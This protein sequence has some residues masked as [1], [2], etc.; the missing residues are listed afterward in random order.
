MLQEETTD[1]AFEKR[2]RKPENAEKRVR[3]SEIDRLRLD[4]D[5]LKS[6]VEQLQVVEAEQLTS[7][8][9]GAS[10]E[11]K[12]WNASQLEEG[13]Q[14]LIRDAQRALDRHEALLALPPPVLAGQAEKRQR[15]RDDPS[16]GGGATAAK[17]ARIRV[18]LASSGS[19]GSQE[20]A[21][22]AARTEKVRRALSMS[23]SA[24]SAA[25]RVRHSSS[26]AAAAARSASASAAAARERDRIHMDGRAQLGQLVNNQG[27]VEKVFAEEGQPNIHARTSGGR[28]APKPKD[29]NAP[30]SSRRS[31]ANREPTVPQR[32]TKPRRKNTANVAPSAAPGG[33]ITVSSTP[34]TPSV[35]A[36][37]SVNAVSQQ[38]TTTAPATS[39]TGATDTVPLPEKKRRGRPPGTKTGQGRG[40]GRT[41]TGRPP[42]RPR[43]DRTV[44]APGAPST[45]TFSLSAAAGPSTPGPGRPRRIS[46]SATSAQLGDQSEDGG[47]RSIQSAGNASGEWEYETH[48]SPGGSTV[49]RERFNII[50]RTSGGRFA[51]KRELKV[52]GPSRRER[53]RVARDSR[54]GAKSSGGSSGSGGLLDS[55][56]VIA[57]ALSGG[58]AIGDHFDGGRETKLGPSLAEMAANGGNVPGSRRVRI[59]T[60]PPP[61][62]RIAD[63]ISTVTATVGGPS[64]KGPRQMKTPGLVP[65]YKPAEL[66]EEEAMRM[67]EAALA[68]EDDEE[69]ESTVKQE[70]NPLGTDPIPTATAAQVHTPEQ[71]QPQQVPQEQRQPEPQPSTQEE[72]H[73]LSSDSSQQ[74]Q[75]EASQS[76]AAS[77][78]PTSSIETPAPFDSAGPVLA[79]QPPVSAAATAATE[80]TET[81]EPEIQVGDTTTIIILDSTKDASAVVATSAEKQT[82]AETASMPPPPLPASASP[83]PAPAVTSSTG[84]R[85]RGSIGGGRRE[86]SRIRASAAFGERLPDELTRITD[87]AACFEPLMALEWGVGPYA[88]ALVAGDGMGRGISAGVGVG[89][90]PSVELEAIKAREREEEEAQ[91]EKE[92]AEQTSPVK[93]KL[94]MVLPPQQQKEME[95]DSQSPQTQSEQPLY[96][97]PLS[98]VPEPIA[99]QQTEHVQ[100]ATVLA[101]KEEQ[102]QTATMTTFTL[103]DTQTEQASTPMQIETPSGVRIA[104]TEGARKIEQGFVTEMQID[105]PTTAAG[106]EEGKIQVGAPL[107]AQAPDKDVELP[108]GVD[109]DDRQQTAEK[110]LAPP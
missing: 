19:G 24:T 9:F 91:R 49:T 84:R 73:Q 101:Q 53:A 86:S 92:V 30:P 66:S 46:A 61:P 48:I 82:E 11:G 44:S 96:S 79:E 58:V 69:E 85:T 93:P 81:A 14:G 62:Q 51:S 67:L 59:V 83:T 52:P 18:N 27:R 63:P 12:K 41:K 104:A 75:A 22:A 43:K 6:R 1:E 76:D 17:R 13:R 47:D 77:Q 70:S 107:D 4:R 87:F 78:A 100:P 29:P 98:S 65:A 36:S 38:S 110:G 74:P 94:Q 23:S 32:E 28:F 21:A 20:K 25:A 64:G 26:A 34:T 37:T 54:G 71:A 10:S 50:G 42:G 39:A 31:R 103:P 60:P 97:H 102:P 80:T 89:E 2:H 45:A 3:K 7:L 55:R 72:P 95:I 5:R 106:A 40:R 56:S 33:M 108:L 99:Q 16:T 35:A 8:L 90:R 109:R 57:G 88:P 105:A 68:D 15:E